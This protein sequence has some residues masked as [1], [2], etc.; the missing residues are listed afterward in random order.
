MD[1]YKQIISVMNLSFDLK[2]FIY[3]FVTAFSIFAGYYNGIRKTDQR[4]NNV[5]KDFN[6]D[7]SDYKIESI[8]KFAS[9]SD[10]E[11]K[12]DLLMESISSLKK[13]LWATFDKLDQRTGALEGRGDRRK[14]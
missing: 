2:D 11:K 8:E 5:V 13:D 6:K 14:N 10:M 4:I 9:R 1:N 7:M 12:F 3:L